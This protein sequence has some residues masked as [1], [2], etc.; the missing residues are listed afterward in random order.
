MAEEFVLPE[1][2]PTPSG[3]GPTSVPSGFA[4][5]PFAPFRKNDRLGKAADFSSF[6]G[7]RTQSFRGL[8][9]LSFKLC[10]RITPRR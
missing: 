2:T 8:T 10:N 6:R 1:L 3:W 5:I 9:Y 7:Q 4:N